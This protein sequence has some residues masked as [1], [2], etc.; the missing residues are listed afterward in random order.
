[1]NTIAVHQL[2]KRFGLVDGSRTFSDLVSHAIRRPATRESFLALDAVSFT[3]KPGEA[4]GIMGPNGAGKSTLLKVLSRILRPTSGRIEL[5]GR[6]GSLLE[7]GAGFHPELTGRENIFLNGSILGMGRGEI[8][9]KLD[10]IV[11]FAGIGRHLDQ[12]VK[13]YS[14]GMY[15]RLAFAIAAHTEPEILL[16]DEVLAVGDAEFQKKCMARISKLGQNGETIIFVSHNIPALLHFCTR[17]LLL[18]H[19]RLIED[20][21]PSDVAAAYLRMRQNG[22]E[23]TFADERT[24]PGSKDARLRSVRLRSRNGETVQTADIG[25]EL[26][27]EM[28]FDVLTPGLTLF[29]ALIINA[30]YGELF[31]SVDVSTEYHAKPRPAGLYRVV[32]WLPPNLLAPGPLTVTAAL[33]SDWPYVEHFSQADVVSFQAVETEGGSRGRFHGHFGGVVRPWLE[34]T[35][36]H[37]GSAGA[38]AVASGLHAE[39]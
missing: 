6:V 36:E 31:R 1:M 23:R 25:L 3:A 10:E 34:W 19:G 7:I 28:E 13:H 20:G 32:A 9:R 26:G 22:P 4:I 35:V 15:M 39:L 29:P 18:E 8:V 37:D 38:P 24:A 33:Y 2:S 30:E 14:S 27:I 17:A 21:S 5:R 12:P 16:L 11:D